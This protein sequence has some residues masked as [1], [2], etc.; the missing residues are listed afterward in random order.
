MSDV[1]TGASPLAIGCIVPIAGTLIGAAM[2]AAGGCAAEVVDEGE[3]GALEAALVGEPPAP[4]RSQGDDS[5]RGNNVWSVGVSAKWTRIVLGDIDGDG[6]D[7]LCGLYGT[8][9]GCVLNASPRTYFAGTFFEA[10]AF[11]GAGRDSVHGTIGVV[12]VDD[13]GDGDLCGRTS[14]GIVCQTFRP[15]TGFDPPRVWLADFSDRN[16]WDRPE[17]ASTIGFVR[18]H[19][20][21]GPGSA[22]AVCGRGIAGVLC[23]FRNSTRT[24]FVSTPKLVSAFSDRNGWNR[25][26]Y[27]ETLQYADID[28]DGFD[29]VCGRGI[30][31]IWCARWR[32]GAWREFESPRLWTT[33][34][35]D[36][37]GWADPIYYRSIRLGDVNGDRRA[38]VCGRGTAGVYCGLARR[39]GVGFDHA[40]MLD[41]PGM[42]NARGWSSQPLYYGSLALVDFDRDGRKDV[43]GVGPY[44]RASGFTGPELHCAQSRSGLTPSFGGLSRR[45]FNSGI[46]DGAVAGRIYPTRNNFCWTFAGTGD[47][48][49]NNPF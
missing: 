17:Y 46:V 31:G 15:G 35:R 45:S 19:E 29:D 10:D 30:D 42:S 37:W 48:A 33:Q 23:H 44:T 21:T 1:T 14:S 24:G 41:V 47:V 34:F 40:R 25:P 43:C 36:G 3:V 38:D 16:G 26:E 20:I 49:C 27:Y 2:A 13:D 32:D 5:L 18:L 11:D 6:Q 22:P 7:D 12:D 39:G 28:G 4:P 8:D 9:Y